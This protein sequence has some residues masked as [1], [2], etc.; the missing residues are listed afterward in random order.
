M[1][2]TKNQYK[3]INKIESNTK[4]IFTGNSFEEAD[5]FI[6]RYIDESIEIESKPTE[7]Q[8]KCAYYICKKYNVK[9]NAKTKYD[10]MWFI[11]E[12]LQDYIK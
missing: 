10:Y 7:K 2:V 11:N 12:Y 4:H 3:V 5:D 9:C 6:K 8:K 1:W